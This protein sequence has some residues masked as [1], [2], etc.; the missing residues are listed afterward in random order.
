MI[1]ALASM[2]ASSTAVAAI[3]Q[4]LPQP[5]CER[6]M[7]LSCQALPVCR[8][9]SSWGYVHL[10]QLAEG[11]LALLALGLPLRPNMDQRSEVV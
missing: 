10:R 1:V 11:V 6:T 5:P 8:A 9:F 7:P 4:Q 3:A 2:R